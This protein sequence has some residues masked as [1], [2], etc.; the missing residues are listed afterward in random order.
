MAEFGTIAF[1]PPWWATLALV[2]AGGLFITAGFWQLD[3]ADQKRALFAGFDA[4]RSATPLSRLPAEASLDI[5]RYR[6]ID[7]TGRYDTDRQVLLD[8]VTAAGKNGY[9]V[10]TPLRTDEGAVM[11]N[12]GWIPAP[13]A[14][15]ELPE[16]AVD[17]RERRVSAR[18]DRLPRPGIRLEAPAVPTDAPWPR[19]LLYPTVNDLTEQVGYPLRDYQLLLDPAATDGFR[20]EWRPEVMGPDKHFGYAVQWFA[21]AAAITVI[22]LLLN[23]K[24][25]S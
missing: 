25:R 20:R 3:R 15:S 24:R 9:Q 13:A 10:L 23:V 16:I 22:Y 5:E 7:L 6:R 4:G 14:R 2:A 19:R 21:F 17:T 12:R 8:N 11:V 1:R 18:L